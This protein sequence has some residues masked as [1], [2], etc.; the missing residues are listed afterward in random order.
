MCDC[1]LI[2]SS[3]TSPRPAENISSG[4]WCLF[5]CWK[6]NSHFS[7]EYNKHTRYFF[8]KYSEKV[9]QMNASLMV[10]YLQW[11][12]GLDLDISLIY[13]SVQT[14]NKYFKDKNYLMLKKALHFFFQINKLKE[15][16]L[17]SNS[18]GNLSS[19]YVTK[20]IKFTVV[21]Q[22]HTPDSMTFF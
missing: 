12:K 8:E 3:M 7:L 15:K 6:N 20:V 11:T 4:T 19:K 9:K 22:I 17:K 10:F 5:S 1:S 2:V 16:L 14:C 18:P 13:Y 21:L